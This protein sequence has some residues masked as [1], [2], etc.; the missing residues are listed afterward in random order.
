M[1]KHLPIKKEYLLLTGSL[2]L[3]VISY[4]LAFKRTLE[5]WQLHSRLKK[6]LTEATSLRD[7][8]AYLER[9]NH[10][11][12]QII[13][14]YRTDTTTFRSNAISAIASIAEKE[15]VKLSEVPTQDPTYHS[16]SFIIQKLDFEGDFFALT[17]M[18][19][20]LQTARGIGVPRSAAFRVVR[21]RAGDQD[22]K[23]LVLEVYLEAVK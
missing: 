2:L 9:K 6:Q 18:Y 3:L 12:D 15:H 13:D 21:L 8:P 19:S 14:L 22:S 4:E 10:N 20:Q 16:G 5:A 17:K 11:L 7:Q 23:K 1:F